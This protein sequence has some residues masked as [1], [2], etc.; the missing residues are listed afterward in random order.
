MLLDIQLRREIDLLAD[1]FAVLFSL[2]HALAE[3][4]F[5]LPV[6][7]AEVILRPRGERG[8]EPGTQ[9]QG[10]LFL[11]L[12]VHGLIKAAGVDDGLCVV[13]AAEDDQQV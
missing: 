3:Q 12:I 1:I 4:V 5:D 2:A 13:V 6:D 10:N 7:G 9:A 8:I 11:L